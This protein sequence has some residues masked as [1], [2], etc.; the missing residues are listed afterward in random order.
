MA[1]S[2]Y[3]AAVRASS[4][5]VT[6]TDAATTKLSGTGITANT[7]YQITNQSQRILAPFEDITV[8]VDDSVVSESLYTLDRL[9]GKVTFKTARGSTAQV[10]ISGKYL[11]TSLVSEAY[12]FTYTLE[13]TNEDKATFASAWVKKFQAGKDFSAELSQWFDTDITLFKEALDSGNTMVVEFIPVN[14]SGVVDLR[15]WVLV[16]SRELSGSAGGLLE[17]AIEFNGTTDK[18]GRTVSV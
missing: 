9:A 10:T 15:A 2:G 12:E 17:E 14:S 18:D 3:K 1:Y 16:G 11:P 5:P 7:Q 6:L 13:G 8:S 4:T